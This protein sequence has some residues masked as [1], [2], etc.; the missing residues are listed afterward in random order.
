MKS[1]PSGL[2]QAVFLAALFALAR[3]WLAGHLNLA[4]DEAYYWEWSRS[5]DWCYYDQG[6]MLALAIRLGTALL[7]TQIGFLKSL[8]KHR[9]S[10]FRKILAKCPTANA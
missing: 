1:R 3:F 7:G 6:P 4:E 8:N 10:H 9:K 5:L 2:R